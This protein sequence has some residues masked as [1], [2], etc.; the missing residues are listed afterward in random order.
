MTPARRL[1]IAATVLI[2]GCASLPDPPDIYADVQ[3]FSSVLPGALFPDGWQ[4]Y[5]L[6]RLKRL[7]DYRAIAKDGRVVMRAEADTSASGLT[8]SVSLDPRERPYLEWTWNVS[9]ALSDADNAHGPDD[10][11]AR[12][13]VAFAGD[14]DKWDFEDHAFA[15]RVKIWSGHELPYA[16]LMYIWG[17]KDAAGTVI[18]NR[19]SSRIR[20]IVAESGAD[21]TGQWIVERRNL[22]ED[23]KRAFGEEPG[24]IISVGIMSDTDNT[25]MKITAYYG[26][27][28]F[29]RQ[30]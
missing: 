27:I 9:A 15:G 22:Y 3:P 20:M 13:V 6:S 28:H 19:H 2:A 24:R 25:A 12:I 11:P 23:Y 16:T 7:T 10:A 5:I 18:E 30:P 29:L 17:N 21:N 1:L 8:Q 4:P 26:D 14:K